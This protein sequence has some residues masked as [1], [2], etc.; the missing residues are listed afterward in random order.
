MT[1]VKYSTTRKAGK[2]SEAGV[3][4][5]SGGDVITV[6]RDDV[7]RT[8]SKRIW[9]ALPPGK[10]GWTEIT[11]K[12]SEVNAGGGETKSAELLA[13]IYNYKKAFEKDPEDGLSIDQL[14]E[15]VNQKLESEADFVDHVVT[16][17]D[18]DLN[19]DLAA[20]G[21]KVGETIKRKKG[22]NE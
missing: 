6:K 4:S 8:M 16:Q 13:A 3:K 15:L 9:D 11:S 19:P 18:L 5:S 22:E 2:V 20:T 17:E 12:P 7:E 21:V 14:N 1:K 10:D